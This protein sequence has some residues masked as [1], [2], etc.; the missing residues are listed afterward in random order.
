MRPK[1]G[2]ELDIVWHAYCYHMTNFDQVTIHVSRL[3]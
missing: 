2:Y 1:I 3:L